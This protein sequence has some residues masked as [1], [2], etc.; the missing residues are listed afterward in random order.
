[1]QN[2][3]PMRE[4]GGHGLVAAAETM[5]STW[6]WAPIAAAAVAA[7]VAVAGILVSQATTRRDRRRELY[8]D[9]YRTA[10]ALVEMVYRVRRANADNAQALADHFH[11]LHERLNF[12][13]GWIET[14]SNY[15][16]RAYRRFVL[17]IRAETAE[18]LVEAWDDFHAAMR[19]GRPRWPATVVVGMHPDVG[20]AKRQFLQDVSDHLA[21]TRGDRL[22]E[23][24]ADRAWREI[25]ARL[26]E[27]GGGTFYDPPPQ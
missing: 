11:D 2:N 8:A 23:R 16:G 5:Q 15:M 13:Q 4:Y 20:I 26:P 27:A 7:V 6:T 10:L 9:A 12:H 19:E 21:L 24:Y 25:R 22:R 3:G 14:E 18:P 1:M 17:S